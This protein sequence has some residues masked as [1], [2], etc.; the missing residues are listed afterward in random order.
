MN[1]LKDIATNPPKLVTVA[2]EPKLEKNE[3]R[4]PV[5]KVKGIGYTDCANPYRKC[6]TYRKAGTLAGVGMAGA[7]VYGAGKLLNNRCLKSLQKFYNKLAV[8]SELTKMLND[9]LEQSAKLAPKLNKLK[10]KI[11]AVAFVPLAI[12]MAGL[13]RLVGYEIDNIIEHSRKKT[14][15]KKALIMQQVG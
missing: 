13:G 4:K 9:I 11:G 1:Y 15:D 5:E 7:T 12:A 8:T 3:E 10:W 2:Q 6:S 14:A